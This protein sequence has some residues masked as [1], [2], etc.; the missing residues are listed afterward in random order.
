[1]IIPSKKEKLGALWMSTNWE[2]KCRSS[3]ITAGNNLKNNTCYISLDK[4]EILALY[5]FDFSSTAWIEVFSIADHIAFSSSIAKRASVSCWNKIYSN[6]QTIDE[7]NK[8]FLLRYMP[9]LS[10]HCQLFLFFNQHI[11]RAFQFL[12]VQLRFIQTTSGNKI[13]MSIIN[14]N[15]KK[16]VG[17]EHHLTRLET[18]SSNVPSSEFDMFNLSDKAC[19]SKVKLSIVDVACSFSSRA[20]A[21]SSSREAIVVS[22][23]KA[24][25]SNL[26]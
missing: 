26:F 25:T 17:R 4:K 20:V 15:V 6:N 18:A 8:Y 14:F 3:T 7:K 19:I 1:M 24:S 21:N 22:I 16:K 23:S 13:T 9:T 12:I 5:E 2:I 11:D 10:Y